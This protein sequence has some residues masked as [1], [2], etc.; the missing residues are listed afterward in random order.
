MA[1]TLATEGKSAQIIRLPNA[2][3]PPVIQTKKCGRHP[4]SVTSM[5]VYT[6]DRAYEK[7]KVR[8]KMEVI[9]DL[10][11]QLQLSEF[12][13]L[14]IKSQISKITHQQDIA[15]ETVARPRTL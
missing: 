14:E 15:I 13:V 1:S 8:Q 12:V 2:D 4:K 7:Y 10:H 3:A 6:S 5:G 9:R 11:R